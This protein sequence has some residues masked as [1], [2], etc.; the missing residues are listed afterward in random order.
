MIVD[1]IILFGNA[2]SYDI[3][4]HH[5]TYGFSNT[6]AQIIGF[7]TVENIGY[8]Y[9]DDVPIFSVMDLISMDYDYLI[10]LSSPDLGDY[11]SQLFKM[12]NIPSDKIIPGMVLSLPCFNWDRYIKI[13]K[14]TPSIITHHCLGGFF[15][16]ALGLQFC[17]PLINMFI[18][19]DS[20][21]KLYLNI[22]HYFAQ[23][24]VH[25]GI[26]HDSIQ[27]REYP[28]LLLDDIKL[29]CNHYDSATEA[30]EAW[31]RRITRV[32]Y[33]NLFYEMSICS[34]TDYNLF[35][36]IP[37]DKKIAFSFSQWKDERVICFPCDKTDFYNT[38][39]SPAE[40]SNIIFSKKSIVLKNIDIFKLF[41]GESDY[42]RTRF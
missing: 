29:H 16:N 7:V 32:N 42:I 15:Y 2:S 36:S 1:K 14:N 38:Y 12:L 20:I 9:I 33:D 27:D 34:D 37:S 10:N 23:Q 39:Q 11:P 26:G 28:I 19:S 21:P 3:Y 24:P 25:I 13:R 41:T 18:D 35:Q 31:Q 4:L 17:S 22:E 30:I 40:L 6:N 8:S 5:L